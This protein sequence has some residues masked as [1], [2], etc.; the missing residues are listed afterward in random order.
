[1]KKIALILAATLI[2]GCSADDTSTEPQA[3]CNCDRVVEV[4]TFNVIGTPQNPAITYHSI[5]TTVNDCTQVQKT[6]TFD[7]TNQLAI[8]KKG[9][10]R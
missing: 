9:E 7:T 10:C 4:T 5:I 1:M 8:P 6:K 3:N 2:F